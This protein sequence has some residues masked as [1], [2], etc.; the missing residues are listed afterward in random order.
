MLNKRVEE[1]INKQINAEMYSA[2]LYQSMAAYFETKN[3]KGFANW[4]N[5]QAKEEMTHAMM[6]FVFR[7]ICS[8]L[9]FRG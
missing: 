9:R 2:Y 3:L 1:E 7:E 4:M 6:K 8:M 5:V